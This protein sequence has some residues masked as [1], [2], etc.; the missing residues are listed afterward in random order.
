MIQGSSN[1]EWQL[2]VELDF[3]R[4]TNFF[5]KLSSILCKI[6]I[7]DMPHTWQQISFL[8]RTSFLLYQLAWRFYKSKKGPQYS[9]PLKILCQPPYFSTYVY[10]QIRPLDKRRY[11][12]SPVFSLLSAFL[13]VSLASLLPPIQKTWI[14]LPASPSFL[15]PTNLSSLELGSVKRLFLDHYRIERESLERQQPVAICF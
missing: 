7:S 4:P 14:C 13:A 5:R 6:D 10:Y 15:N 9:F 2:Y 1:S 12:P 11:P 8:P 3:W